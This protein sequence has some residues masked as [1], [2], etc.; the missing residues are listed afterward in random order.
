MIAET[1]ENKP[2]RKSF[3]PPKERGN[4][5]VPPLFYGIYSALITL[6]ALGGLFYG[7]FTT[8][9]N[10]GAM[11]AGRATLMGGSLFGVILEVVQGSAPAPSVT[12]NGFYAL[13]IYLYAAIFFLAAAVVCSLVLSVLALIKPNRARICCLFNGWIVLLVYGF[14]LFCAFLSAGFERGTLSTGD[15][16]LPALVTVIVTAFLLFCA[17]T[18][19][20]Q[21]QAIFR[22]LL[23][24]TSYATLF[25]LLLPE[26]ALL[27]SVNALLTGGSETNVENICLWI[28][29]LITVLNVPIGVFR[30]GAG[31]SKLFDI[32]RFTLQA[33]AVVAFLV[34]SLV[35]ETSTAVFTD[36][37]LAIAVLVSS[38]FASLVLAALS[39]APSGKK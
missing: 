33:L 5:V 14:L 30:L 19:R 13:P 1:K 17:A 22:L 8:K 26:T 12:G 6:F 20:L 3:L 25:A 4:T 37:P 9:T 23:L 28:L 7:S 10:I 29:L 38:A 18:I 11:I 21:K 27:Q 31:K 2:A 36:Q 15:I 34:A 39:A 32:V 16:D 35:S 24:A